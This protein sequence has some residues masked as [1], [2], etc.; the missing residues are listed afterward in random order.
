MTKIAPTTTLVVSR[1][2]HELNILVGQP[3]GRYL[4]RDLGADR[5]TV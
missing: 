5:D 4:L 1:K 2:V 3:Q